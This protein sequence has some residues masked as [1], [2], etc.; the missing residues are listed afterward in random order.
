MFSRKWS[1]LLRDAR[2]KKSLSIKAIVQTGGGDGK[3]LLDPDSERILASA[4]A[5]TELPSATDSEVL[6]EFSLPPQPATSEPSCSFQELAPV[7][8][9]PSSPILQGSPLHMIPSSISSSYFTPPVLSPASNSPPPSPSPPNENST[10][11]PQRDSILP[12]SPF[13][14]LQTSEDINSNE[15]SPQPPR[16][17]EAARMRT[18]PSSRCRQQASSTL[19]GQYLQDRT[20]AEK[21]ALIKLNDVRKSSA[22]TE[23][24]LNELLLRKELMIESENKIILSLKRETAELERDVMRMNKEKATMERDMVLA[25]YRQVMGHQ[26]AFLRQ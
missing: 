25:K 8:Y 14:T 10:E 6:V 11:P 4:K 13:L 2:K 22:E 23:K 9:T 16:N 5:N 15:T 7:H 21:N 3:P 26:P 20:E 1:S 12:P 19:L 24:S 17:N 18:R